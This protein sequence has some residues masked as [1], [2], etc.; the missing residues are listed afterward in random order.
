MLEII[1][2][3]NMA[4]DARYFSAFGSNNIIVSIDSRD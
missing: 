4:K 1:I 3:M 2:V